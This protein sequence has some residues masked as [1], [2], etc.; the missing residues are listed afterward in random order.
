MS[1]DKASKRPWSKGTSNQAGTRLA[2]FGGIL[3][4]DHIFDA[5][6]ENAEANTELIVTAVNEYDALRAKLKAHK[7]AVTAIFDII[8]TS[9]SDEEFRERVCKLAGKWLDNKNIVKVSDEL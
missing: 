8:D 9:E 4:S 3:S 1:N 7:K 5:W 2:A 6:G